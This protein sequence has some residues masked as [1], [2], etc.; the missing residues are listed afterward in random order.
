VKERATQWEREGVHIKTVSVHYERKFNLGDYNSATVGIQVWA[1]VDHE[2][3][4]KAMRQLWAMAKENVRTQ[5]LPLVAKQRAQVEEAFLGLPQELK[6]E[7]D[8][9]SRSD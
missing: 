7:I 6:E 1:D 9:H 3:A 2:Q 4:D 8:A 5:A